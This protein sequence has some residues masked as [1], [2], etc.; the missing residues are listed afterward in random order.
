MNAITKKLMITT[1][2]QF[3]KLSANE[4]KA[5]ELLDEKEL[6]N[7]ENTFKFFSADF[8]AI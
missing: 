6:K 1:L 4:R 3:F 7:V 5:L 8:L 2:E